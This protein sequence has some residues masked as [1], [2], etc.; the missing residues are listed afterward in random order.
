[1]S[2]IL[3]DQHLLAAPTLTLIVVLTIGKVFLLLPFPATVPL[4]GIVLRADR[5]KNDAA[6]V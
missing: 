6:K 5:V 4:R 2:S 3:G 1:M